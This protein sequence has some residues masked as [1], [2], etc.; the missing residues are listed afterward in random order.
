MALN[1]NIMPSIIDIGGG[2]PGTNN[3]RISFD[4]IVD[5]INNG[6]KEYFADTRVSFI[7][8][9]GRFIVEKS[10]TLILSVVSKKKENNVIKYYLNDGIYGSFNCIHYDHQKPVLIPYIDKK[11]DLYNSSF[12]GPTCDSMDVIYK[13]IPFKELD[14]G[15][16]IYVKNFGAYTLSPST[17]FNGYSV[18]ENKYIYI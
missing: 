5:N 17:V 13:N 10:H 12:F 2:F 1:R 18:S 8:E 11:T 3:N 6:I 9:P 15:D 7:A 14:I 4:D 16:I